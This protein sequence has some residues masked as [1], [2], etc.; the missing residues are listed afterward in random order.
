MGDAPT[1]LFLSVDCVEQQ[2]FLFGGGFGY[3]GRRGDV[4]RSLHCNVL[5]DVAFTKD[6]FSPTA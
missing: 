3:E 2:T 6:V 4:G 5:D 1:I